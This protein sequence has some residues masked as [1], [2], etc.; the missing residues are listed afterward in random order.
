MLVNGKHTHVATP[1]L[2]GLTELCKRV[3]KSFVE[4]DGLLTESTVSLDRQTTF[5][6]PN[7]CRHGM[8][9]GVSNP[10]SSAINRQPERASSL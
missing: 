7:L 5:L 9:L 10:G 2:V 3:M 4:R 6:K 8:P 1:G